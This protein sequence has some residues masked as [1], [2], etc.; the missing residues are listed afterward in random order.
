MKSLILTLLYLFKDTLHRWKERPA[1]PLSR[2]L[3]SFFLSLCA[4]SFLANYVLS[5]KLLQDEI[6]QSGGDLITAY[7][8]NTDGKPS[9]TP[10]VQHQLP[11]LYPC[12][13]LSLK[14]VS[15]ATMGKSH[16]QIME[17][18]IAA[19]AHLKNLP[20][21]N[22]PR[23]LLFGLKQEFEQE[24]PRTIQID[25]FS[26]PIHACHMPPHHILGKVFPQGLILVPAGTFSSQGLR[27]GTGSS[28]HIIRAKEMTSSLVTQIENVLN[29]VA[30]LDQ[31][32]TLIRSTA[33][34][35]RRLDILMGNQAECRAAFSIGIAVIVGIL[36]TALASMEFQQNEY[37]YT[38]MK[39][40]GVR[41]VF[42]ILNFIVE[43]IFLVGGAF[44]AAVVCFMKMQKIVL[45]EF[46]K[47]KNTSLS[48][49]DIMPDLTLLGI[50]L[51]ICVLFSSIPIIISAYRQIGKVLK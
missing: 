2:I 5:T 11:L 38:L 32:A 51:L 4:L 39:S 28:T 41:P 30:R 19:Y 18:D 23:L 46:F 1:S 42:L 14:Q 13:V 21:E 8:M 48:F 33:P 34:I 22:S 35:L 49:Q 6:R 3:V 17:Y 15:A 45:G 20:L 47:L 37:V 27:P 16:Y 36:L 24:G 10:L 12:D 9:L 29:N 26:F 44:V 25:N 7:D 43:N 31:R 50:A 40:F